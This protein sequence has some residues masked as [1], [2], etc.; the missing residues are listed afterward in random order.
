MVKRAGFS[1]VE[2]VVA[3]FILEIMLLGVVGSSV[4]ALRLLQGADA[5]QTAI[6]SASFVLDSLLASESLASGNASHRGVELRWGIERDELW[7]EAIYRVAGRTDTLEFW[8]P[9]WAGSPP[10]AGR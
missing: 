7:L 10:S 6:L 1:L 3:L 9:A 2:V 5:R 4:Y 8:L